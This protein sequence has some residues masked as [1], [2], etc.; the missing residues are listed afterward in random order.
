M[1]SPYSSDGTYGA[2]DARVR[3][4]LQLEAG[5]QAQSLTPLYVEAIELCGATGCY[6]LT[7]PGLID[8]Y[9]WNKQGAALVAD[10]IVPA[11]TYNRVNLLVPS[12]DAG[13]QATA[14]TLDTPVSVVAGARQ[15]IFL[16]LA[17]P[18]GTL[19]A[20]GDLV[21][22]YLASG[23]VPGDSTLVA[24]LT[25]T[26]S[27]TFTFESGLTLT[28]PKGALKDAA[29]M[30]VA[31]RPTTEPAGRVVFGS[32]VTFR[33]PL[34]VR[35]PFSI[36]RL[37]KGLKVSD[38]VLTSG[39]QPVPDARYENGAFTA[40]LTSLQN[41]SI[42]TN[43]PFMQFEDGTAEALPQVVSAQATDTSQCF[44][45]LRA[46]LETYKARIA[47]SGSLY[48]TDCLNIAPYVHVVIV[49]M[50]KPLYKFRIGLGDFYQTKSD[51]RNY[52]YLRNIKDHATAMRAFVA[53]NGP[54]WTGTEG[55]NF[56]TQNGTPDFTLRIQN[57]LKYTQSDK[58]E[59]AVSFAQEDGTGLKARILI[60]PA[61]T[62][63]Y[64]DPTFTFNQAASSTSIIRDGGCS[65]LLDPNGEAKFN[66]AFG[67]GNNRLI[68]VSS[69]QNKPAVELK[70]FCDVFL[71][72]N[73]TA[74]AQWT[75]GAS[76]AGLVYAGD[77][78]N[79]TNTPFMDGARKVLTGLGVTKE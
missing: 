32:P 7:G 69:D 60:K 46:N 57:S 70:A 62:T 17:K 51:G 73:A 1:A 74:G 11:G 47:S 20:G 71:G 66:T 68:F 79:P 39:G 15:E 77:H 59:A 13:I 25:T 54:A 23:V 14:L 61:G 76:A 45:A 33:S 8:P 63:S 31:D 18:L 67:F 26:G 3:I 42:T 40:T 2:A 30:G 34:K 5:L 36:D 29:I 21:P 65:S 37:P 52:F 16:S 48:T 53:I 9:R 50:T 44:N 22:A 75:D 28:V 64:G 4:N 38:Y 10:V 78:K 27:S 72:L 55:L 35:V 6:R 43:K 12:T 19:N 58:G 24:G 41:L 56:G 49:D